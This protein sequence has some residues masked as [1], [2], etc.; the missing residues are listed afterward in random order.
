VDTTKYYGVLI[1][2]AVWVS[3]IHLPR[4]NCNI[5]PTSFNHHQELHHITSFVIRREARGQPFS[6]VFSLPFC[7]LPWLNHHTISCLPFRQQC[8]VCMANCS[9]RHLYI[10][11]RFIQ[12][13]GRAPY[14][15][16]EPPNNR[17]S[18]FDV[19]RSCWSRVAHAFAIRNPAADTW[20]NCRWFPSVIGLMR[21]L[22]LH[23]L[24]R[25]Y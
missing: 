2:L 20:D 6:F 5:E 14:V 3:H 8:F 11:S 15:S 22:K 16:R 24:Y 10:P 18:T 19:L 4:S 23:I 13:T 12:C 21:S 1:S 7:R 25:R 9:S 17:H